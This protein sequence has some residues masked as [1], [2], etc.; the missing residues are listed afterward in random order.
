MARAATIAFG[1]ALAPLRAELTSAL[2]EHGY[3]VQY[4]GETALADVVFSCEL[5]ARHHHADAARLTSCLWSLWRRIAHFDAAAGRSDADV[6]LH[7]HVTTATRSAAFEMSGAGW[8]E[9]VA[10]F[11]PISALRRSGQT[12]RW[13]GDEWIVALT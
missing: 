13:D 11:E 4:V 7:V 5:G 12:L 2:G 8:R 3:D 9:A 6:V 10:T 1:P